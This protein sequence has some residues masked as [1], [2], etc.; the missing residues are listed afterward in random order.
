M[1]IFSQRF[2][3]LLAVCLLLACA[4]SLMAQGTT[5]DVVGTVTDTSGGVLPGANVT[6]K[7]L[8]TNVSR[9][10]TTSGTGTYAFS[11]L[12]VGS[13]SISIE[14]SGFKTFTVPNVALSIGDRARVDAKMEVGAISETV[15]VTAASAGVL[16]TDS[17]TVGG[18][19]TDKAVQ[20][21]PV[22]GRNFMKLVQLAPGA[23]ES[24]QSTLGGGT[25][26]DDRRQTSSVSVNGIN[27][28]A[29][30]FL[31]DGM[32]NNER[33]IA[34]I[35]VKPSIDALQEVKVQTNL[36]GADVGRAGGA[37]I[38]MI[39]KSGTNS[40]HGTLFEFVRNDMFDAKDFFN[41]PQAGNPLAGT[42]PKYRQ[43]Q[44]G[45]SIGGPI[46]KDKTF[47]FADYEALR[48]IQSQTRS[49]K[50]P[51]ACQLGREACN[52]VTQMG[53]F[54]DISTVLNN[55][56][57][58][59][60][61]PS[62]IMPTSLINPVGRNY[63]SLYPTLTK[64]ACPNPTNCQ[65]IS[66]PAR[67][68]FAHT[69]DLRFD[70]HFSD[71]DTLFARYSINDTQSAYPGW[72]PNANVAGISNIN[73][74]GS[75]FGGNFAGTAY[76][77]QQ[78]IALSFTHI[79]RPNLMLQLGAQVARFVTI[80][81]PINKGKMQ[82][83]FGGPANVNSS[84]PGTEGLAFIW[85]TAD[86]YG[87][88]GDQFAL[89][90]AYWDTNYQYTG[91]IVW[92]KGSHNIKFGASML[93][94][95]WSQFQVLFKAGIQVGNNRSGNAMVNLMA[96]T[97]NLV[98]RDLS[99]IA[100]QYRTWETGM[101]IQDDWRVNNWLTLNLGVR[102]D[103]FTP[104]KEKFDHLSNF[105]ITKADVRAGGKMWIA[106]QNGISDTV[107]IKTQYG[108]IQPRIGFAATIA[109]GTVLRG[110]FGM[111]YHPTNVASPA[112]LKNA[113][114]SSAATV[115]NAAII[116]GAPIPA[117]TLSDPLPA[118]V[119]G[120]TCLSAS[121]GAPAGSSFTIA[122]ATDQ[123]YKYS[124]I[125]M[126]NLLLEKE[127]AGNVLSLGYI[128]TAGRN[129][130]RIY[131]NANM[132]LPPFGPGGCGIYPVPASCQ[133]YSAELPFVSRVQLLR[134]NGSLNYNAFQIIFQRRYKSG[135]TM[136]SNYTWGRA[137][138]DTGGPGGACTACGIVLNNV[139]YDYG[140]SDFDVRHRFVF[141]ANYELPF[142]KSLTGVA[143]QRDRRMGSERNLPV[144][145]R[146]SLHRRQL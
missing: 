42:K 14:A 11:L 120:A 64:A 74:V 112:A 2:A 66:S 13:Y 23:N 94:R 133:P 127:F 56:I 104:L 58:N 77:R 76:Q 142:G 78:S 69:A 12:P 99:L 89:P 16:Q 130:G 105:D 37:V 87:G 118:I 109:K 1:L 49:V 22:N 17:A 82:D 44:F 15:E 48:I 57:T 119:P 31:L 65:F 136:S 39:T 96:G 62:N 134:T 110:G 111:S 100:P 113:P 137:L 116:A 73:V 72:L 98:L 27:D 8:G 35:I 138:A 26:P 128:G 60:P 61:L 117:L 54:S 33:A 38:N 92:T 97:Y 67:T 53:N 80:S 10:I 131:N 19:V 32:D 122:Q 79:F 115:V 140:N 75:G 9:S 101:Y 6:I 70:H 71:K 25:R 129:L 135:L 63:A 5:A 102:Y 59:T 46:I 30:N 123:D 84:Y 145:H 90:T 107:N 55:P 81:E 20:D 103:I 132:P 29:N 24:S 36:Y 18:L 21:L 3:A 124:R 43:N 51:T 34:T 47:F 146:H 121:C 108:D 106:G 86:G 50:I 52:G 93:R 45:G 85:F 88:L 114:F 41:V 141:T 83:A 139:H 40:F 144:F 95:D 68:Q 91:N 143:R 4:P 126:Y 125:Y 7:N 28:Q